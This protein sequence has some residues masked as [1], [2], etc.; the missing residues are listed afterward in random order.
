MLNFNPKYS[1]DYIWITSLVLLID[2]STSLC[3]QSKPSP[4]NMDFPA[5][6]SIKM[7][8]QATSDT[9]IYRVFCT[10]AILTLKSIVFKVKAHINV[11]D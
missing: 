3:E 11:K 8:I 4:F 5:S 7:N 2:L 6:T 1:N 9:R 10:S